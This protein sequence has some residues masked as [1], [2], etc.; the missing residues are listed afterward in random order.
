MS[1]SDE[2]SAL[3]QRWRELTLEEGQ[4][5]DA[6]E[7]PLVELCQAAKSRLQP[8][9]VEISQRLD[10]ATHETLFR[11]VVEELMEL[12]RRNRHGLESRRQASELERQ[13]LDRSCRQLRQLH[14]SYVPASRAAWQSY[15]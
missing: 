12:E 2:L 1:P 13:N 14:R 4:A 3:Y 11:P 5:I 10:L 15:S 8:R 9:I 7:W 6:G